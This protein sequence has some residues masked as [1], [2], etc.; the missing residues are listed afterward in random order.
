MVGRTALMAVVAVVVV[1]VVVGV[2]VRGRCWLVGAALAGDR[3]Y[4]A[5]LT[6][7]LRIPLRCDRHRSKWC[8]KHKPVSD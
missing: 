2:E 4:G 6:A 1:V 3:G 7:G 8:G 5:G